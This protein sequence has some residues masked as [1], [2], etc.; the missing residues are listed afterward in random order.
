L[1]T[2][3]NRSL[4][5][6]ENEDLKK[7]LFDNAHPPKT[8]VSQ[9][10]STHTLNYAYMH[11]EID[12]GGKN[13]FNS[14]LCFLY[15]LTMAGKE[16]NKSVDVY[17]NVANLDAL[18]SHLQFFKDNGI[19]TIKLIQ[20]TPRGLSTQVETLDS[21]GR[22]LRLINCFPISS[23]DIKTLIC[24]EKSIDEDCPT[25]KLIGCSGDS[26]ISAALSYGMIPFY[27]FRN[28][29][30]MFFSS[31]C[32]LINRKCKKESAYSKFFG[33]LKKLERMQRRA[34]SHELKKIAEAMLSAIKS[35]DFISDVK[36]VSNLIREEQCAQKKILSIIVADMFRFFEP[37]KFEEYEKDF[38]T[39]KLTRDE[40]SQK[41]ADYIR[42]RKN[43]CAGLSGTP[44]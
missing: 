13:Y 16:K 36:H 14:L 3:T 11:G 29:K 24:F 43:E 33:E 23:K 40:L 39:K 9:Y 12:S 34:E 30:R 2:P 20:K 10:L 41:V 38:I 17:V 35:N 22:E 7:I 25:E 8:T 15:L 21:N 27:E 44:L 19:G 1:K 6:L 32:V 42:S 28:I 5:D 26:S 31:L 37:T 4:A 18:K